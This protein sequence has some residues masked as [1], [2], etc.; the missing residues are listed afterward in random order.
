MAT[1]EALGLERARRL[2]DSPI[3]FAGLPGGP[4]EGALTFCTTRAN[5]LPLVKIDADVLC[6]DP[7]H[8]EAVG[9]ITLSANVFDEV[10][11]QGLTLCPDHQ[12]LFRRTEGVEGFGFH[13]CFVATM[14]TNIG[15][16]T[17][18]V[19]FLRLVTSD[20][21][22]HPT[23][24]NEAQAGK[25]KHRPGGNHNLNY[26]HWKRAPFNPTALRKQDTLPVPPR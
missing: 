6:N 11:P 15:K 14:G 23:C 7:R 22:V 19:S 2:R 17:I 20:T 1:P 13:Q 4:C 12:R 16:G 18:T 10:F 8:G 21:P 24:H 25:E 26:W 3:I 9:R 5:L